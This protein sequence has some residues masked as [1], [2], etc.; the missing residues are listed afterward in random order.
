MYVP[1]G[2]RELWT[3]CDGAENGAPILFIAGANA[4]GLMWPDE[5]VELFIAEGFRAIRYDHRD[6]GKSTFRRFEECPYSVEDLANDA[7]AVLN[8]WRVEKSHVV[9]LSLGATI[10]Q[11]LALDYPERLTSMTLMCGAALDVDFVGNIG[12]AFSGELSPDGLPLPRR[13]ALEALAQR[14]RSIENVDVALESRVNEWQILAGDKVPFNAEEFLEWERRSIEHAG[15]FDLPNNHAFAKP[16]ALSRGEELRRVTVPTL[17]IQGIEDPLN[18]PPHGRH[19]ADLVPSARLV[20]MEG[21]GHALPG[22]F[23]RSI[24]QEII[25][26]AKQSHASAQLKK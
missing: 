17:V 24:A 10:G 6:T 11:V 1:S 14:S 7:I 21:L 8:G 15:S 18:P 26:H 20:E 2:D 9:G 22:Y 3:R 16:V 12:R 5:F 13:S 4:S 23:H 25:R 19:I